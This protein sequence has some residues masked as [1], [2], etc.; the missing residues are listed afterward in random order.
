MARTLLRRASA[1]DTP[2]VLSTISPSIVLLPQVIVSIEQDQVLAV[3]RRLQASNSSDLVSRRRNSRAVVVTS[4]WPARLSDNSLLAAA[5]SANLLGVAGDLL[6]GGGGSGGGV[7]EGVGV[8]GAVVGGGAEGGVG[9]QSG[10]GVDGDELA[11]VAGCGEEAAGD[12]E[13]SN[14]FR[15]GGLARVDELVADGDCV[16][17]GPVAV[18]EGDDFGDFSGGLSDV[19]DAGEELHALGDGG[20]A[21]G[22]ELVAVGAVDADETV[23]VELGEV[24][25]DLAGGLAGA[26]GVVGRV[27]DTEAAGAGGWSGGGRCCGGGRSRCWGR[28]D[29][30][31]HDGS[32]W[33]DG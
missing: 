19:V 29:D 6:A 24:R 3:E 30:G 23:A 2:V 11:G 17:V 13:S 1:V 10:P 25:G 9:D 12:A 21:D 33:S 27:G 20:G 28:S 32:D 18:G 31:G 8:G 22:V 26:V 7:E 16:E 4:R 14:D 5:S 15:D